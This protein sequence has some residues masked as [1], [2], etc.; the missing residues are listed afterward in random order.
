MRPLLSDYQTVAVGKIRE[1]YRI[2]DDHLLMVASDRI[3]AF[4]FVL[5]SVIP[6]KGRILT[7]MSWWFFNNLDVNHHVVGQPDDERIPASVLGRALVVKSLKMLPVECVARGYLTGSG[8][9]EYRTNGE[10]CGVALPEG[11]TEASVLNPVIYTPATK[12]EIGD[13]DE[14]ISFEA[15]EKIVGSELAAALKDLTL[16]IY[17]DAAN[18][19]SA[20]GILLADTKFEFGIDNSGDIVLAD[21]V[22]TP[23]SSRFW[24]K[25]EYRE[26]EVQSSFDKQIVRNWLRS[27]ESGWKESTGELPPALPEDVV[28]RTRSRYIEAYE[29]ITGLSFDEW[30]DADRG[31]PEI[32][33]PPVASQREHLRTHHGKTFVDQYE[34]MRDKD[35]FDVLEHL[36]AE[37]RHT[38]AVTEHMQPLADTIFEEIKSRIKETDMSVPVRRGAWWYYARTQE[39]QQYSIQCRLPVAA[40]YVSH[41]SDEQGWV[42]PVVDPDTAADG[43][44]IVFDSNIESAG[45][46]FFAIGACTMNEAGTMMAYAVDDSGDER[47]R[48][49]FRSFDPHVPAPTEIIPNI[50]ASVTWSLCGKYVFYTTVDESWRPDTIWRHELGADPQHD[51]VVMKENDEAYWIGIGATRSDKYLQIGIGS[52]ITNEIWMLDASDPTGDFWC[53]RAREIGVEYDVEHAVLAQEDHF[54]VTHNASCENFSLAI[55]PAA[56]IQDFTQLTELIP[57]SDS[58]RLEGVD[59][60]ARTLVLSYRS[61]ALSRFSLAP[62]TPT[63]TAADIN[64]TPVDFDEELFTAGVGVNPNWDQPVLRVG[65]GSFITPARIMDYTLATGEFTVLKEQEVVGGYDREK[66]V[67]QRRWATA[68]D[69]TQ[70]P[71]SLVM[72]AATADTISQGTPAALLLYGYGSYEASMDPSFSV[73]RLSLLDRGMVFAVAHVRGGGEMGRSWYENGKKLTKMNTFTDFI[74]C[75]DHLLAHGYTTAEQMV[76]EGGSAGGLLMGA[77]ANMAPDRFAGIMANVPFVDPLTSILMPELPLTVIEWDEWGNPL[78]DADVYDYMASYAPYENITAQKYPSILAITSLNDTRVLYVE[79]AKWVAKLRRE[80]TTTNPVLLKTEM[81]AGHG[82][83]SGRYEQWKQAGFEYAWTLHTAG[84]PS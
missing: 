25:S 36:H 34:W 8:L 51:V 13:H 30:I 41:P 26:G 75:A 32:H 35:S 45:L 7:A 37:N 44:E 66:Y 56:P 49:A 42:P 27:E 23:D 6:D 63:S 18:I 60:Y 12:A 40:H 77:V 65:F 4:D 19:A 38:D 9:K 46:Q 64:F 28:Q 53:V 79:P 48:L 84:I 1:L 55:G 3:S 68:N 80:S 74:S 78:A 62:L 33:Q 70:I 59:A 50:S 10:V 76:A 11:L 61:D 15:T 47:Y 72:S 54:V 71:I 31:F 58:I 22:L 69:G 20:Q 14:N 81:V 39:G 43:E 17:S 82:G 21:E 29:K 73:A 67:Q 5:D 52:K 2:D 16:R 24:D 83:V 57:G